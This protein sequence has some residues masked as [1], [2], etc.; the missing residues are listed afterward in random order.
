MSCQYVIF[1][2]LIYAPLKVHY[3]GTQDFLEFL[4][5][6]VSGRKFPGCLKNWVKLDDIRYGSRVS[7][8]AK[9]SLCSSSRVLDIHIKFV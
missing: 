6:E 2:V 4:T 5:K 3:D 8:Y 1:V 7:G 9:C